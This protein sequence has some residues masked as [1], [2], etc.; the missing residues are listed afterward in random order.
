GRPREL[1][2]ELGERRSVVRLVHV[3]QRHRL[4]PVSLADAL[5]VREGD[6]DARHGAGVAG[7][8]DDVDGVG[9][10]ATNA[11]LAVSRIPRHAILEPLRRSWELP[12]ACRLVWVDVVPEPFPGTLDASGVHVYLD[13]PVDGVNGRVPIPQPRDV[14]RDPIGVIAGFVEPD[15]SA[16]LRG[17]L[18][19]RV[20]NGG[21]EMLHDPADVLVVF[22]ADPV[23]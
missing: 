4:A 9:G 8:D 18:L 10:D 22:A 1:A 19:R 7:F 12:G 20:R 13:E 16:K 21:L 17:H 5:V 15:Q 23:D 3:R 14:V 6:T 2:P 11:F